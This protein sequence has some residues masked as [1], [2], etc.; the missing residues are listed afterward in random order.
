MGR[1]VHCV[2]HALALDLN[3]RHHSIGSDGY[4]RA[5]AESE[6]FPG[7]RTVSENGVCTRYRRPTRTGRERRGRSRLA[8]QSVLYA[9]AI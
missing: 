8:G 4:V 7:G 9:R 6:P 2:W 3:R 1:R 5:I